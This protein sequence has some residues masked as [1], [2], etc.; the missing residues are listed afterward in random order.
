MIQN[1]AVVISNER[2]YA[3]KKFVSTMSTYFTKITSIA[4]KNVLFQIKLH[5]DHIRSRIKLRKIDIINIHEGTS[6]L[7]WKLIKNATLRKYTV[8]NNVTTDS[9]GLDVTTISR[10]IGDVVNDVFSANS[11]KK[12]KANVF[13]INSTIDISNDTNDYYTVE[14][15][16][17][18][19]A[20]YPMTYTSQNNYDSE[21][22]MTGEVVASGY[23]SQKALTEID[24][25]D[26]MNVLY[27]NIQ[28]H[29]DT[30]SLF[31]EY[32]NSPAELQANV[33]WEEFE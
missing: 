24:L 23:I 27:S 5:D 8:S 7:S 18:S 29:S 1:R 16:T 6:V 17:D 22:S 11:V 30:L 25:A 12:S 14:T 10:E 9:E 19:D 21:T 13:T 15:L 33:T 20:T 2:Y 32:I 4:D 28:G 3:E 31:I 26:Q